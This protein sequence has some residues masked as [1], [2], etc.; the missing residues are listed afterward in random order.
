MLHM[1]QLNYDKTE[2]MLIHKKAVYLFKQESSIRKQYL[3]I[4]SQLLQQRYGVSCDQSSIHSRSISVRSSSRVGR[5]LPRF[6]FPYF[7]HSSEAIGMVK[8]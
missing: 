6:T 8:L 3:K 1:D 7:I 4:R 5:L 2:F